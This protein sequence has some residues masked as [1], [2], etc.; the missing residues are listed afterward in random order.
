MRRESI[1]KFYETNK[2]I[3]VH[4]PG[5]LKYIKVPEPDLDSYLNQGYLLGYEQT[6]DMRQQ[7]LQK[8]EQTKLE[9]YGDSNYNNIEKGRQTRLELYGDAFYSNS[10]QAQQTMLKKY[11]VPYFCVTPK[12]K[13]LAHTLEANQKRV[14]TKTL[15]HS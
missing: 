9:R 6:A 2:L 11:G 15:N 1:K 5:Q 8:S 14:D 4:L 12:Y 3:A 7:K 10:E 13:V